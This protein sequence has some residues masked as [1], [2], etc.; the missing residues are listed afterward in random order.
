ME[1]LFACSRM[2]R[3]V[4]ALML[5]LFAL[6]GS[7]QVAA[8]E[9]RSLPI[10]WP[11]RAP[12]D[13]FWIRHGFAV[14][15]TWY[16]PGWWHCGEDWYG[17]NSAETGGAEVIAIHDGEVV[18]AGSEYPGRVVII[19][20]DDGLFAM[21]GHLAY[22]PD[23]GMGDRVSG[24]DRIGQ[25][26]TR[27]DGMA[28]SHLHFELRTF[29][30]NDRVNGEHPEH[31][32]RCGFNCPPGPGYWPMNAEHPV[33][34]GWL[35]PLLTRIGSLYG[36]TV[37]ASADVADATPFFASPEP[38]AVQIGVL[39]TSPGDRL[40][41]GAM[42]FIQ[43]WMAETS[44]EPYRVCA[45]IEHDGRAGWIVLVEPSTEESGSDGRPSAARFRFLPS[46]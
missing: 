32:V 36:R 9:S 27:T 12:G 40:E 11:D 37:V 21:Y 20:Q 7:S 17:L 18:Y 15:N 46:P 3:R 10:R 43:N 29:L 4:A 25:V 44:S 41:I 5:P 35:N 24:G 2:S 26:F 19:K 42:S 14:E 13:G 30:R 38:D 39:V 6:R 23:V 34:L 33:E 1:N 28:P 31:G 16:N 45:E 22:E 8:Q